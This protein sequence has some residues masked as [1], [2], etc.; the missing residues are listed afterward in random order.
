MSLAACIPH[1]TMGSLV[2]VCHVLMHSLSVRTCAARCWQL[3]C[4]MACAST[5]TSS[6][7]CYMLRCASVFRDRHC[8]GVQRECWHVLTQFHAGSI[9]HC[10]G[11]SCSTCGQQRMLGCMLDASSACTKAAV[12]MQHVRQVHGEAWCIAARRLQPWLWC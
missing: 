1:A 6:I 11:M 2:A 4:S 9:E 7:V 12:C 3:C 8:G 10:A 5:H